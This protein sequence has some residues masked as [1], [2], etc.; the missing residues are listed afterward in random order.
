[1]RH[2]PLMPAN[3]NT[4]IY[5][6]LPSYDFKL[7][8]NVDG[9]FVTGHSLASVLEPG[10]RLQLAFQGGTAGVT[11]TAIEISGDS[12]ILTLTGAISVTVRDMIVSQVYKTQWNA[13]PDTSV[14]ELI[15]DASLYTTVNTALPYLYKIARSGNNLSITLNKDSTIVFTIPN[16]SSA[17]YPYYCYGVN[18]I[19]LLVVGEAVKL[20]P[21]A[22]GDLTF[23]NYYFEA[24]CCN[25]KKPG[26][27]SLSLRAHSAVT[28][29]NANPQIIDLVGDATLV[30]GRMTDLHDYN[31][32]IQWSIDRNDGLPQTCRDVRLTDSSNVS[33]EDILSY[34]NGVS[35]QAGEGDFKIVSGDFMTVLNEPIPTNPVNQTPTTGWSPR[36]HIGLTGDSS[37]AC[38]NPSKD[39]PSATI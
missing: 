36:V 26:V 21:V 29:I 31:G 30:S 4:Q 16:Y 14:C 7:S 25:L 15:L 13:Y 27:T 23:V 2:Y 38:K 17:S 34:I 10:D 28:S 1:M 33:C 11:V 3:G 22:Y 9:K 35:L 8:R 37:S 32:S 5:Y 39:Y 12:Y 20:L 18:N 19:D 6:Q 24:R